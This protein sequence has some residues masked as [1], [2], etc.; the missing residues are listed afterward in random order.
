VKARFILIS[1]AIL[2]VLVVVICEREPRYHGRTLISW[3][4]QYDY[5]PLN[6]SQ[7]RQE[8][9]DA[10]RAIGVK[11]AL[12]KLL[13]LVQAKD[14]PVSLWLIDRTSEFRIRF[15]RWSSSERY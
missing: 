10:V 11:K 4:Q 3:L 12:P 5:T 1:L 6:E 8:A 7:H 9:Q 15:L 2:C 13:N 14:D